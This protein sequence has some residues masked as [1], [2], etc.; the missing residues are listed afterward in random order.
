MLQK[1]YV[2]YTEAENVAR[3]IWTNQKQTVKVNVGRLFFKKSLIK[4][5]IYSFTCN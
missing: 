5:N 3:F 1:R 2:G 4:S